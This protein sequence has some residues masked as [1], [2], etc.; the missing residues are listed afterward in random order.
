[1]GHII[2]IRSQ[3]R[4]ILSSPL[5]QASLPAVKLQAVKA[6]LARDNDQW[7]EADCCVLASAIEWLACNFP[8]S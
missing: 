4:D 1:M 6:V 2:I 3:I 8:K 7:S 5:V